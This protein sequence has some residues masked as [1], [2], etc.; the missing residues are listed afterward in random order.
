MKKGGLMRLKALLVRL[1]N[2]VASGG[3]IR[4]R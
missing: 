3:T 4:E 2:D 1:M